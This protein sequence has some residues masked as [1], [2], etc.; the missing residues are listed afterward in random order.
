V[1]LPVITALR[2]VPPGAQGL[3]R[4]LRARWAFEEVEQPYRVELLD[5]QS[6]KQP[7]H[8]A[9]QPFGQVPTLEDGEVRIFESGAIVLH[10]ARRH[11]GLLPADPQGEARAIEWVFAALTSVEPYVYSL[12]LAALFEADQ[13]WSAARRPFATDR[14]HE[15][16]ADLV[17]GFGEGPWL[18]GDTFTAGDLMMV[19]VLRQLRRTDVL[20]HHP[21]LADY[22]TRAEARPAFARALA[23]QLGNFEQAA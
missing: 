6:I 14:L 4:D 3:V 11:P 7:F 8:R 20:A 19:T 23:A 22:V 15:R 9:R 21:V 17:A 18:D 2:W 12:Q 13:P 5:L 10:I 16:L 1:T